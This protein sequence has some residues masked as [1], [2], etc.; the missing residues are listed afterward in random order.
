MNVARHASHLHVSTSVP[1]CSGPRQVM[2][3]M[4]LFWKACEHP[5]VTH[6]FSASG[7]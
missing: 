7:E 5:G 1:G 2:Q 3:P 4:E 6:V